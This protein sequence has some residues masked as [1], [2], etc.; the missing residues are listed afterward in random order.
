MVKISDYLTEQRILLN[1]SAGNKN[2]VIQKMVDI[3]RNDPEVADAE[4][5][6]HDLFEREELGTTGIGLGLAL[7][8]ARTEGVRSLVMLIGRISSPIDF[9]SLDGQPVNL[10]F[11]MGTPKNDVQNYLKVLA[12]LTRLLKKEVFRDALLHAQ[13]AREVLECFR[14]E[15]T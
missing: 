4:I 11:L 8:H 5:F 15:E 3:I 10:I 12:H 14:R 13:D 1:L 6:L 7:P 9:N 2:E